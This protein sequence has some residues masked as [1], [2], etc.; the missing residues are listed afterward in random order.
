MTDTVL[1]EVYAKFIKEEVKVV[2]LRKVNSENESNSCM[3]VNSIKLSSSIL[4]PIL[5]PY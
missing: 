5:M 3:V 4:E 2:D 1:L